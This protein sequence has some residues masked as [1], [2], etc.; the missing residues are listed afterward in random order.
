MKRSLVWACLGLALAGVGLVLLALRLTGPLKMTLHGYIALAL[1]VV[2][3]ALSAAVL[4]GL[5]FYSDRKGYD[6]LDRE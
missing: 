5:A 2:L 1:G 6:D 3:T 4:M